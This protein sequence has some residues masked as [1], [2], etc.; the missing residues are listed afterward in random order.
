MAEL[1][2]ADHKHYYVYK[3]INF[4]HVYLER[5]FGIWTQDFQNTSLLPFL[6]DQ[7]LVYPPRMEGADESTELCRH[8]YI[9]NCFTRTFC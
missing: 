6:P 7:D 3:K 5:A 8:P 9:F 4:I 1:S 2:T